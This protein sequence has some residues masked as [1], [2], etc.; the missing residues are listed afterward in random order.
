M[1]GIINTGR[2]DIDATKNFQDVPV[3]LLLTSQSIVSNI[4]VNTTP[5]TSKEDLSRY[6]LMAVTSS[7]INLRKTDS[8]I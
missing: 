8:I 3:S 5:K 2:L 4:S 6:K 1:V 7:E